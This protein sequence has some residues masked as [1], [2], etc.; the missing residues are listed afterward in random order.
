MVH[1]DGFP[2]VE[3]NAR[4][5]WRVWL[6]ATHATSKG[7]WVL[8]YKA[9]AGKPRFSY[10]EILEETLCFGWIDCKPNKYDNERK[11]YS[12]RKPQARQKR[13]EKTATLAAQNIRAN[14][15]Q[16]QG[17]LI[18]RSSMRFVFIL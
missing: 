14:Q 12:P 2:V 8:L 6:V 3:I 10:D 9:T 7:M 18:K 15:Y 13:V 11:Y 1:I 4:T 16:K 5:G 17:F